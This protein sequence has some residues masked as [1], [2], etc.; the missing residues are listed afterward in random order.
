MAEELIAE[1]SPGCV[2]II[3]EIGGRTAAGDFEG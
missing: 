1:I 3:V 2:R